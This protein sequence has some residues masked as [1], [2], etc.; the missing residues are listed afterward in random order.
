MEKAG[1]T[2]SQCVVQKFWEVTRKEPKNIFRQENRINMNVSS[3]LGLWY[4][5][6]QSTKPIACQIHQSTKPIA[7]QISLLVDILD[8]DMVRKTQV[9]LLIAVVIYL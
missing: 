9:W 4:R 8:I 1:S 6:H 7:R 2:S 5:P 3:R